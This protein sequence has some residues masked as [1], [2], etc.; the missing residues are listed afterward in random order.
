MESHN[1]NNNNN[2]HHHYY[3]CYYLIFAFN[4]MLDTGSNFLIDDYE[5]EKFAN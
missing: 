3:N 4:T 1:H 5:I 2:H